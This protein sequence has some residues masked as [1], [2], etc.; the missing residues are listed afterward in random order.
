MIVNKIS[1]IVIHISVNK[2][3]KPIVNEKMYHVS[4][5]KEADDT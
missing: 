5:E 4:R 3:K 2:L 1:Y